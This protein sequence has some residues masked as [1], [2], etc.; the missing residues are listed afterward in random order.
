MRNLLAAVNVLARSNK[1]RTK[2][3]YFAG[4]FGTLL[5]GVSDAADR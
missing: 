4:A 2:I 3:R 5:D 1:V